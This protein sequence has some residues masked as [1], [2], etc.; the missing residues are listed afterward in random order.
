VNIIV[1][2]IYQHILITEVKVSLDGV[3]M[4]NYSKLW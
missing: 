2:I 1:S 3:E 4:K